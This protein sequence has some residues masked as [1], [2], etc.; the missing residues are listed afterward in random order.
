MQ[1]Q[2]SGPDLASPADHG[3]GVPMDLPEFDMLGAG[4]GG[5]DAWFNLDMADFGGF[6]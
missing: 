6:H 5:F 3:F 2:N 4:T 1:R